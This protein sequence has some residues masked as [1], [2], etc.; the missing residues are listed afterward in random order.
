VGSG[1]TLR[2]GLRR[3]RFETPPGR[4]VVI[5]KQAAPVWVPPEWHYAELAAANGWTPPA[6][7]ADRPVPLGDGA[8]LV[9][10]GTRVGVVERD[11]AFE[12]LPTDEEI[13]FGGTLYMPPTSTANRRVPGQLGAYRLDLGD[14]FLIH[15]TPNEATVG[16]ASSHGCVR[17]AGDALAWVFAHVPVGTVV[18]IR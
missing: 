4:R 18:T 1:N 10:R 15:G 17:L 12:A 14:G 3:W 16:T 13:V 6:A 2:Y 7:R 11:G 5:G 9:V 8:R